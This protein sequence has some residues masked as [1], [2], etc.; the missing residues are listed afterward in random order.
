MTASLQS[1]LLAARPK[2]LTA[3]IVPVVT[4]TAIAYSQG[5][6]R[7]LPALAALVGALFIQVGTN[8]IND[9]YDFK[10]GADTAERLGPIRVTQSGLIAPRT[11]LAAAVLM[12]GMATL[13]GLYL[14]ATA[15]WPVI[16]IGLASLAAGYAYTG[17][18]YPLAY[19][20][21][22]DAFVFIFF[23]LVAV[24]GTCFVQAGDVS[25]LAWL[26]GVTVG[27]LGTTLIVVNNLRDIP[28]D[29]KAGKRTMAVR[30]GVGGT[31]VEFVILLM[32]ALA[33][34]LGMTLAGVAPATVLLCWL[35]VPLMVP[36]LKLVFSSSGA[37]LNAALAGCARVQ[38]V[39]GLLF[40][41]GLLLG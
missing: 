24:C 9:Y 38:L 12:F 17:G 4:G 15:G 7:W 41:T 8:L 27:A 33:T 11:V 30:L 2:T 40:S 25:T 35:A 3:A 19:H 20:G 13:V 14:F 32:V 6:G 34:P 26:G 39:F 5:Q 1:W 28:T 23:G 22:G 36:P 29:V 18:P 37:Q 21:L 31:R 16:I 10:K